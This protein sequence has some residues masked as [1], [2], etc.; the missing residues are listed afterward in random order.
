MIMKAVSQ[1]HFV[2]FAIISMIVSLVIHPARA[3]TF[4][5]AGVEVDGVYAGGGG[6]ITWDGEVSFFGS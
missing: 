5:G 3:A 1:D 2:F 6:G 4:E